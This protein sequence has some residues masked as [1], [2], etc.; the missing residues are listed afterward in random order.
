[1]RKMNLKTKII[2]VVFLAFLSAYG[3]YKLLQAVNFFF[4]NYRFVFKS[5]VEIKLNKPISLEKRKIKIETIA[6]EVENLPKP[7]TPLEKYICDKFGVAD[8]KIAIAVAKAESGLQE[9]AL[10]I[11]SN[12]TID[13]GVFQINSVHWKKPACHPKLLFDAYKNV[14]C[15]YEIWRMQGWKPWVTYNNGSFIKSL[16]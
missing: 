5:P 15:A 14:D 8:C 3:F 12:G 16:K 2:I 1:M 11:N 10:N 13:A 4:D 7:E 6:K 9:T